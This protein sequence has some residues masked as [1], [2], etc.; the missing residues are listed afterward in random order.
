MTEKEKKK[1][2]SHLPIR[3]NVLFLFVFLLFSLLIFRL[4]IVQIV[5]GEMYKNRVEETEK[6]TA[7]QDTARG[8]MYDRNG[9]VIV[10]NE[11]IKAVIY[12]RTYVTEEHHLELARK[13]AKWLDFNVHLEEL[14]LRE[15][16]DMWVLLHGL[17]EAYHL[18]LSKRELR[19]FT[20]KNSKQASEKKY[21]RLLER[22]TKE[23]IASLSQEQWE[24]AI[25]YRKLEG[26]MLM[27]PTVIAQELSAAELA[28][29][30]EHLASLPGIQVTT[31]AR[32]TYPHGD[33]FYF[34][35]LGKI[36][37]EKLEHYL[38]L[39]YDRNDEI[40]KS[41]L[42][43]YYEPILSGTKTT[44]EYMMRNG[45][46]V[47][48]P[49][50]T[51]GNR[52]QDI[53]LTVDIQFQKKIGQIIKQELKYGM[54]LSGNNYLNS[55][56]VVA[57]NPKTG[58]IYALAGKE[59]KDGKFWDAAYGTV[60]K[61]F[62][63][64]STVKGATVL[65]GF[66]SGVLPDEMW[67]ENDKPILLPNGDYFSS[68]TSGIGWVDPVE[69]LQESSNVYMAL[70]AGHMAGFDFDN[71]GSI[72][73][74]RVFNGQEYRNAFQTLRRVY[75]QFGLGVLTGIDLPTESVGYEGGIP[76]QSGKIFQFSIGQF[77]TYTP[78]QMAQYVATIA[79][80]GYRMRLHFLKSIRKP[81]PRIHGLGQVL[82]QYEPQILNKISM[83]DRALQIVQ[84]GF[85]QVVLQGTAASLGRQYPEL[86]IAGKTGTAQV[87][88][89]FDS[90]IDTVNSMFVGYAPYQN[91]QIAIAVAVPG[92]ENGHLNLRI[93]G[94]VFA[95]FFEQR[96]Y[97]KQ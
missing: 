69:A 23:D 29:V 47:G 45:V 83:S 75:S 33:V 4:G 6:V 1:K 95:A 27:T 81:S 74:V 84:K 92:G 62:A 20:G 73:D 32:R 56:Y 65:A 93:A 26:A 79:N 48:E 21:E 16:K 96:E 15:K 54:K 18:K 19:T 82:Y 78:L 37:E 30:G 5:N 61:S 22:I 64:G 34:G 80:D 25:L 39:G 53:V 76:K 77:D 51:E 58:G 14:A 35:N 17:E 70:I 12:T 7:S 38:A 28:K 2:K 11:P 66:E 55:A 87:D 9:D 3:L 63:I 85:R 8:L 68:Y 41:Y 97:D 46:P 88:L 40:G 52:G 60:L 67:L 72:Y 24:T 44:F 36:Q 43:Q 57:I 89:N 91:P 13:L 71:R 90:H 59:Y 10:G 31:D 94:R 49:K 42:E 50:I 86:N